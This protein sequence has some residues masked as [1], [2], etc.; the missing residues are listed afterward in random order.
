MFWFP[1][2]RG[3]PFELHQRSSSLCTRPTGVWARLC[4]RSGRVGRLDCSWMKLGPRF[5]SLLRPLKD[6]RPSFSSIFIHVKFRDTLHRTFF[7]CLF[8]DVCALQPTLSRDPTV[9]TEL[10]PIPPPSPVHTSF[11]IPSRSTDRC[12][13]CFD[14]SRQPHLPRPG[15]SGSARQT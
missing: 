5:G 4:R 9:L 14:V 7:L 13:P 11:L 8:S 6:G 2:L 12:T 10:V 15:P 1:H 3:V